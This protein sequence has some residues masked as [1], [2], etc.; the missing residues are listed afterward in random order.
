MTQ[1]TR[2]ISRLMKETRTVTVAIKRRFVQITCAGGC[3]ITVPACG[4][5]CGACETHAERY[6][7]EAVE[8]VANF[9]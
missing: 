7:Y 3:G 9:S 8:Q 6:K 1:G 2:R 4:N 5:L